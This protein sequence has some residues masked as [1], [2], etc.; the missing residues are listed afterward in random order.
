MGNKTWIKLYR[1]IKEKGWY[2]DSHYVHLWVHILIK[3]NHDEKEFLW[4]GQIHKT[5]RG[6][7]ITGR[8]KLV[9]ETGI[10]R[11]KLERVLEC[12]EKEGQIEQQKN[13]KFRLITVLN[14]ENYQTSEQPVSNKRA[15][16]EQPVSTYKELKETKELKEVISICHFAPP[17]PSEVENY[18]L[19]RNNGIDHDKWHNFYSSKGW[20]VGKNKMKDWR[21]CVRTWESKNSNQPKILKEL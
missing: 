6:Q 3:A 16:S 11:S 12:F 1:K 21:A 5:K 9:M 20:M 2:Q 18:C 13:N 17:T 7:F 14:Y 19:E 15:T 10:N 4:N 8:D